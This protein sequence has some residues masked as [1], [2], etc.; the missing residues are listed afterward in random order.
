LSSSYQEEDT[1]FEGTFPF[2]AY[3]TSVT[4]AG[5]IDCRYSAAVKKPQVRQLSVNN[6]SGE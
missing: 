2:V 1:C 6:E 3:N 5:D 4:Y